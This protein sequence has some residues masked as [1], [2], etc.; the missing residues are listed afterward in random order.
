VPLDGSAYHLKTFPDLYYTAVLV[1]AE[2]APQMAGGWYRVD[3]YF[4]AKHDTTLPINI[5]TSWF[6]GKLLI[7]GKP[8]PVGK[9]AGTMWFKAREATFLAPITTAEDGSFRVRV[10]KDA[11]EI[12]FK[13][14]LNTYPDYASGFVTILPR[15]DLTVDQSLNLAYETRVLSGPLRVGGEVVP[16]SIPGEELSLYFLSSQMVDFTWPFQGGTP[17]YRVRIPKGEYTIR[18]TIND[19]VYPDVAHGESPLGAKVQ[20]FPQLIPTSTGR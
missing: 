16:D 20:V 5:Q 15:V 6:E 12:A 9:P 11:Y 7:D 18:V 13:T 1:N 4:D 17:N 3:R 2:I 10:A 14:D 19:G 8:P